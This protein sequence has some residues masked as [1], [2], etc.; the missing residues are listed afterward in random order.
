MIQ[1]VLDALA[2]CIINANNVNFQIHYNMIGLAQDALHECT[3]KHN[4]NNVLNV[5]LLAALVE[6]L[7]PLIA[8][9][10]LHFSFFIPQQT[11]V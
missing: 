2:L 4:Q 8:L 1:H 9:D 7:Y 5:H 10:V 6:V 11:N 3:M